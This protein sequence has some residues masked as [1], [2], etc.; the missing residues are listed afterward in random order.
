[1][2]LDYYKHINKVD[3]FLVG[4]IESVCDKVFGLIVYIVFYIHWLNSEHCTAYC[5]SSNFINIGI[6]WIIISSNIFI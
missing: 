1:M 2:P 6:L 4:D 3:G 5:S